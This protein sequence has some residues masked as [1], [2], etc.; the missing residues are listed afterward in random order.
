MNC[1]G[2]DPHVGRSPPPFIDQGGESYTCRMS[3]GRLFSP[4]SGGEQLV[5]LVAKRRKAWRRAW[6]PSS[7]RAQGVSACCSPSRR[8][9]SDCWGRSALRQ[10][11]WRS[12]VPKAP[13]FPWSRAV[14]LFEGRRPC[15]LRVLQERKAQE[16]GG[17]MVGGVRQVRTELRSPALRRE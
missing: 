1:R 13:A 17:T 14:L 9:G 7:V 4:R 16:V 15:P 8:R 12:R 10:M 3:T 6:A 11:R 5:F 2:S